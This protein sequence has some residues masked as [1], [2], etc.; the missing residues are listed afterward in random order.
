[1]KVGKRT[2]K[3]KNRC[4][5]K[6]GNKESNYDFVNDVEHWRKL[7]KNVSFHEEVNESESTAKKDKE[8]IGVFH[9]K[10]WHD[11][12]GLEEQE[13][14]APGMEVQNVFASEVP[15]KYHKHPQIIEAKKEELK[16][17]ERI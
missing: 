6:E 9:L 13:C 1:M 4:W 7:N 8:E 16:K 12:G 10:N 5:I 3:D 17:M 14:T 15:K 2:S 11:I